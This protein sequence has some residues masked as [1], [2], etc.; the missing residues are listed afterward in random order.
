[1]P[2]EYDLEKYFNRYR[3]DL[4]N[5][6][7][8]SQHVL[9]QKASAM[10]QVMKGAGKVIYGTSSVGGGNPYITHS[11]EN[12][13]NVV[14]PTHKKGVVRNMAVQC[15]SSLSIVDSMEIPQF[16]QIITEKLQHMANEQRGEVVSTYVEEFRINP[17]IVQDQNDLL[18]RQQSKIHA[19]RYG[20][21]KAIDSGLIKDP[22]VIGM[23]ESLL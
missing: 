13:Y 19:M 10:T 23:L 15:V 21:S 4:E 6:I 3:Q 7:L 12:Y 22:Y 20:I 5:D 11:E 9:N 14:P 2:D 8:A 16:I 17:E 18:Q 1:M